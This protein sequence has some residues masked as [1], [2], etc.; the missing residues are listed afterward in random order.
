[1]TYLKSLNYD[2]CYQIT[3]WHIKSYININDGS[4]IYEMKNRM[5]MVILIK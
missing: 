1:M 3:L 5:E 4:H 2:I